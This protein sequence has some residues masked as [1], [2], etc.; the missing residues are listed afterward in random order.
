MPVCNASQVWLHDGSI[1]NDDILN[2]WSG[3]VDFRYLYKKAE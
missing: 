1:G 3:L 2:K